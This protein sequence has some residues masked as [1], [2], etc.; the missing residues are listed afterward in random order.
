MQEASK[1]PQRAFRLTAIKSLR[2][3]GTIALIPLKSIPTLL[4]F[5]NP[6]KA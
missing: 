3:S 1:A 4:K 5:A 6:H 2:L